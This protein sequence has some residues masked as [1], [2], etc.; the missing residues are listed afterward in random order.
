[1]IRPPS[2]L[3]VEDD[4]VVEEREW[5]VDVE[6]VVEGEDDDEKRDP[7]LI[8]LLRSSLESLL[9]GLGL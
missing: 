2:R 6:G 9:Y 5:R 7:P 1:M 8:L 3:D 4:W